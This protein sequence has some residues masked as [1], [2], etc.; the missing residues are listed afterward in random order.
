MDN[1]E[2]IKVES[3]DDLPYKYVRVLGSGGFGVVN[4]VKSLSPRLFRKVKKAWRRLRLIVGATEYQP[5][6]YGPLR[7]A[8]DFCG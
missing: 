4:E 2:H 1:G 3:L 5:T 7:V 6:H 8:D